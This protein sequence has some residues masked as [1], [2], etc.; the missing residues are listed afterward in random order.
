MAWS[1]KTLWRRTD[2]TIFEALF[3]D[4]EIAVAAFKQKL[5]TAFGVAVGTITTSTASTAFGPVVT[6]I[7]GGQNRFRIVQFGGAVPTWEQSR[8]AAV[9]YLIANSTAWET[10]A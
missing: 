8:Q 10:A 1:W 6:F 2:A 3:D 7:Q 9:A 4:T 5:A